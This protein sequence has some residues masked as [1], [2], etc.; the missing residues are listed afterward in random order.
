MQMDGH[1][2]LASTYAWIHRP[3]LDIVSRAVLASWDQTSERA[4][5]CALASF[6]REKF[7]CAPRPERWASQLELHGSPLPRLPHTPE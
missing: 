2:A 5:R 7:N 6:D 1:K 4:C 3:D